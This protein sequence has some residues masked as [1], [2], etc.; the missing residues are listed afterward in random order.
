[1]MSNALW[2][3]AVIGAIETDPAATAPPPKMLVNSAALMAFLAVGTCVL[4]AWLVRRIG[5]PRKL[6][7]TNTPRRPNRVN[8]IHVLGLFGAYILVQ[9]AAGGVLARWYGEED[10]RLLVLA[11]LCGQ[12]VLLV[13]ALAVAAKTFRWGLQRGLGLSGR[14]WLC[15]CARGALGYMAVIPVCYALLAVGMSVVPEAWQETHRVLIA[16]GEA[17]VAWRLAILVSTV[18][19]APLAEELLFRG[20]LQSMLRRWMNTWLAI[21]LTSLVFAAM[22]V[23]QWHAMGAIAALSV[24]LGYNYE[25]TGRLLP[26]IVMHA[27]FNAVNVWIYLASAS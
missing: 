12:A 7:L 24:A 23:G 19:L 2:L 13:A 3:L 20:L 27:L 17:S 5:S 10:F 11:T 1:M 25:R 26:A 9:W 8:P 6:W 16:V 15:D 18:L 21:A 4:L 22:H 14:H